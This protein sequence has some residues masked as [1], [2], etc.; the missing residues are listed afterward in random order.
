MRRL[1]LWLRTQR[2]RWAEFEQP[3]E[4]IVPVARVRIE[5]VAETP[6][7][8]LTGRY[9]LAT[10]RVEVR[11]SGER[12]QRWYQCRAERDSAGRARVVAIRTHACAQIATDQCRHD[13][14]RWQ[15]SYA[16][17]EVLA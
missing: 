2:R 12:A 17:R 10:Y 3:A 5:R 1:L 4:V 16:A 11:V 6:F 7:A 13:A 8:C 9:V 14:R 15:P